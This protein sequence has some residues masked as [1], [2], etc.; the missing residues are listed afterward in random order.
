MVLDRGAT[1]KCSKVKVLL[2][3]ELDGELTPTEEMALTR[4]LAK[5]AECAQEKAELSSLR[6]GMSLWADE[7]PSE[8]LAQSFSYKLKELMEE[9][10]T[11]TP[12][13]VRRRW[14]VFG[15]ATAGLATA[16]LLGVML[17]HN[18]Q[19]PTISPEPTV[20]PPAIATSHPVVKPSAK[21]AQQTVAVKP[22]AATEA[23]R[24]AYTA[25]TPVIR[26]TTYR[27]IA[28]RPT[29]SE[30]RP[31][32]VAVKSAPAPYA[33]ISAQPMM[34]SKAVDSRSIDPSSLG[35]ATPYTGSK[36]IAEVTIVGGTKPTGEE[37]MKDNI[38]EAGLAMNEN[39]EKLRGKLQEAV[40]LLV[41]KPPM[42]VKTGADA[43][44]GNNP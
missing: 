13:P 43:N 34:N 33:E 29:V 16:L 41:S 23:P 6:G 7:E 19:Q 10:Q 9:G 4:H 27:H 25:P 5:C 22:E 14:G 39:V 18:Q 11:E 40:D 37:A 28:V 3:A 2:S 44:G 32:A 20:K 36:A 42:P 30:T 26:T 24:A 15:P 38:G 17:L 31:V 21:L 1:M 12:R 8:W 35:T